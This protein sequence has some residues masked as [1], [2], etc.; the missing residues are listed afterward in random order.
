MSEGY[1]TQAR[2]PAKRRAPT[3]GDSRPSSVPPT[4]NGRPACDCEAV[5]REVMAAGQ[6]SSG[7]VIRRLCAEDWA[8]VTRGAHLGSPPPRRGPR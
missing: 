7:A 1:T 6:D 2:G 8:H 5:A 4:S 3:V